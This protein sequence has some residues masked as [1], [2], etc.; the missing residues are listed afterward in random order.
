MNNCLSKVTWGGGY[1][2]KKKNL[3]Y[4]LQFSEILCIVNI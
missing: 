3:Y 1:L 4:F 2:A